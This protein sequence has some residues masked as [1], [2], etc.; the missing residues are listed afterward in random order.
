M[1]ED[2]VAVGEE[3]SMG[4]GRWI[5]RWMG[6]KGKEAAREMLPKSWLEMAKNTMAVASDNNDPIDD[7]CG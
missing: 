3:K 1:R 2:G 5:G 4:R 7:K 6:R